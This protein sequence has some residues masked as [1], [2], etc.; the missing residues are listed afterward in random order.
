MKN[1][2]STSIHHFTQIA[3]RLNF[4]LEKI[5]KTI[6]NPLRNLS[7]LRIFYLK[8]FSS[9]S[10]IMGLIKSSLHSKI[11]ERW[12]WIWLYDACSFKKETI[13][14][15]KKTC[16]ILLKSVKTCFT[17]NCFKNYT[18]NFKSRLDL[19]SNSQYAIIIK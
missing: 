7:I 13:F 9:H 15:F 3:P 2:T 16:H 8:N 1:Y 4:I 5:N 19:Q 14:S 17:I 10:Y 18:T 12:G 11:H 6:I